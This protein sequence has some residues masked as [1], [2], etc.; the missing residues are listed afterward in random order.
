MLLD[1]SHRFASLQTLL[2][3]VD[4]AQH[5]KK[6]FRV[7]RTGLKV[8]PL[9]DEVVYHPLIFDRLLAFE[10]LNHMQNG[11]ERVARPLRRLGFAKNI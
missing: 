6:E 1:L 8:F 3:M 5:L 2:E 4:E 11:F 9:A 10:K 7:D